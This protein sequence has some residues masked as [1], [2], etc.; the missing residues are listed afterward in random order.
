MKIFL[1][2][3]L[4]FSLSSFA[5]T[6]EP[7]PPRSRQFSIDK[8]N[9]ARTEV[10]LYTLPALDNNSEMQRAIKIKEETCST[11]RKDFYGRTIDV[12]IN[13][14]AEGKKYT[15]NGGNVWI[16][17]I[18]SNTAKG[19]QFYFSDF[20][21]PQGATLHV[22][23]KK[24]NF[25]MGAFTINNTNPDG[26]FATAI[27]PENEA[28][29]E[30]FEPT[31][32][33][34]E[35][36]VIINKI[37]HVFRDL[38]S[39]D[40]SI[41]RDEGAKGYNGS[42]SCSVN[43]RCAAG[44]PVA[45]ESKAIAMLSYTDD[46][47]GLSAFCTGFLVN[48]TD[49]ASEKSPYLL[50]AG[51]CI[52][53]FK[54]EA[55][56]FDYIFYFN[57]ESSGCSNNA[58]SPL[59]NARTIQG[60]Y[61]RSWSDDR[62]DKNDADYLLLELYEKPQNLFEVA[63]LGWD[64]R[65]VSF[66][67]SF[68]NLSHPSGD[69]KK[70]AIGSNAF[71]TGT[72]QFSDCLYNTMQVW[73]LSWDLGITQPGSSGSPLL[74][75]SKRVIGLLQGGLSR[76]SDSP[77]P[78]SG[79]SCNSITSALAGPDFFA[80]MDYSW[81]HPGQRVP[82]SGEAAGTQFFPLSSFLDKN[83]TGVVYIDTYV[84]TVSPPGGGSGG[85][86][87]PYRIWEGTSVNNPLRLTP[88]YVL[89]NFESDR[90]GY[91]LTSWTIMNGSA[92]SQETSC[93]I[94]SDKNNSAAQLI[95]KGDQ[96]N[97]PAITRP[98][99][100]VKGK[101]YVISIKV[102]CGVPGNLYTQNLA[103]RTEL[104]VALKNDIS[105]SS[106][107]GGD[108][109]IMHLNNQQMSANLIYGSGNWSTYAIKFFC[110]DNYNNIIIKFQGTGRPVRLNDQNAF[111]DNVYL[112]EKGAFINPLC[113]DDLSFSTIP[114]S[115]QLT[116]N[117]ITI[118]GNATA[119][120]YDNKNFTSKNIFLKEG[121]WAQA[122]S[123]FRAEA[124]DCMQFTNNDDPYGPLE[125][126]RLSSLARIAEVEDDQEFVFDFSKEDNIFK[127]DLEQ[128]EKTDAG[129]LFVEPDPTSQLF[130]YPNP[131]KD[132]IKVLFKSQTEQIPYSI[133]DINGRK[134]ATGYIKADEEID[135]QNLDNG[136]YVLRVFLKNKY[137]TTQIVV[138][139]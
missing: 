58:S 31:S 117:S 15:A 9:S 46:R 80:R 16:L 13:I 68:Y 71:A 132:K 59:Y 126:N 1:S 91:P 3:S 54:T 108:Q 35:G 56:N 130:V 104:F 37:I 99:N 101:E 82:V 2:I 72:Q 134:V 43:N 22:Y 96:E 66:S 28:V 125:K 119:G 51:H 81:D 65:K 14:K 29:I 75:S 98:F 114:S 123:I 86:N 52:K 17:N 8:F 79:S 41:E 115:S 67:G 120:V 11:C 113:Q 27:F 42:G 93:S 25:T 60:A 136:V 5:Q 127:W 137:H 61:L 21:L 7:I 38:N 131:T 110:K 138:K 24:S 36:K 34:S 133:L 23:S 95:L 18:N 118:V 85:I 62:F 39:T 87:C 64:R 47:S 116:N 129:Q 69:A 102:F 103:T 124:N 32:S 135:L 89:G 111:V 100:F 90:K 44:N 63:Y 12:K 74:N 45:T 105:N 94:Y 122:G 50:T 10:N 106:L 76:C 57:Y 55:S 112:F 84:P 4:L 33:A 40:S 73:Q 128:F 6:S 83:N 26:K 48:S 88:T 70:L 78:G 53:W 20:I 97:G 139:K 30:Y 121:F 107:G 49:V 19:F 109:V 77:V 92:N